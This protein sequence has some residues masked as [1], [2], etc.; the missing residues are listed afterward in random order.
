MQEIFQLA[1]LGAPKLVELAVNGKLRGKHLGLAFKGAIEYNRAIA[2][3]DVVGEQDEA[4]RVKGCNG[5]A[6]A[7]PEAKRIGGSTALAWYCGYPFE[8]DEGTGT[9]GCLIGT[10]TSESAVMAAEIEHAA[11][12]ARVASLRCPR[13][14][15]CGGPAWT[16]A[17]PA[18]PDDHPADC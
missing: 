9:C 14:A 13:R 5:C 17:Q 3:G 18:Q 12:R 7:H 10:S 15:D 2:S 8:P 4:A 11:G 1:S 6:L 16:E